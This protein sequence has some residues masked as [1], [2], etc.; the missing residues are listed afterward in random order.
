MLVVVPGMLTT[1][2]TD[3]IRSFLMSRSSVY[4]GSDDDIGGSD[5]NSETESVSAPAM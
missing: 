1:L 3:V 4:A 2:S 5:G